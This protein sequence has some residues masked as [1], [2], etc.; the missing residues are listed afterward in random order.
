[1]LLGDQP[2]VYEQPVS[3]I[4]FLKKTN[5]INIAKEIKFNDREESTVNCSFF[6]KE[7]I[8]QEKRD[9]DGTW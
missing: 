2:C 4:L 1:M 3:V 8:V 9:F 7:M 5:L 6:K